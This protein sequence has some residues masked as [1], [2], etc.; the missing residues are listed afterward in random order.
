MHLCVEEGQL[1]VLVN[2]IA[3]LRSQAQKHD[4][5]LANHAQAMREI[6]HQITLRMAEIAQLDLMIQR[7]FAMMSNS[8]PQMEGDYKMPQ[9]H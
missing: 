5:I 6:Q 3:H 7:F 4:A 9:I 8:I 2:E 1:N